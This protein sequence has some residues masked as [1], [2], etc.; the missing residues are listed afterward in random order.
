MGTVEQ[1]N[2]K[3]AEDDQDI[4]KV[5]DAPLKEHHIV[6]GE[7]MEDP[8]DQVAQAAHDEYGNAGGELR[9][10][11]IDLPQPPSATSQDDDGQRDHNGRRQGEIADD[12]EV[13]MKREPKDSGEDGLNNPLTFSQKPRL[14]P[15]IKKEDDGG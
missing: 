10:I 11:T 5:D 15:E 1:Q 13:F 4:G 14:Q 7:P 6:G 8:I 9:T 12:A 2:A 3:D